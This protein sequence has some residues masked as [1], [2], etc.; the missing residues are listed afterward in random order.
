MDKFQK[1]R[2]INA[3]TKRLIERNYIVIQVKLQQALAKIK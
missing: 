3:D 1:Q 2:K